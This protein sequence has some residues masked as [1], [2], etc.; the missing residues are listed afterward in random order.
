MKPH[1]A[2]AACA[3]IAALASCREEGLTIVE[4][5]TLPEAGITVPRP[6]GFDAAI[7]G[8]QLRLTEGGD[9]RAPRDIR[10]A[11]GAAQGADGGK[12][13]GDVSYAI[14]DAGAGSGG[15]M[16]ELTASKPLGASHVTITASE[17]REQGQP[18]FG[19]VWPVIDGIKSAE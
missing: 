3:L 7:L 12:Q 18:D 8:G 6:E 19:W 2:V 1:L 9:L 14:T 11:A 15:T 17:Q 5:V 4:N 13:R 16:W 10:V